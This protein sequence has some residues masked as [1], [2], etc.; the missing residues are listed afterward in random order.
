MYYNGRKLFVCD[1]VW[2]DVHVFVCIH[3]VLLV[4]HD[5]FGAVSPSD[6]KLWTKCV[7]I[8]LTEVTIANLTLSTVHQVVYCF[9]FLY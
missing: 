1:V 6:I 4:A 2:N 8:V 5:Q 7:C 9:V 3:V